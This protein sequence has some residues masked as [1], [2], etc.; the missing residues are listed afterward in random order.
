M[1]D[2]CLLVAP[3][4]QRYNPQTRRTEF[5]S[6]MQWAWVRPNAVVEQ[7]FSPEIAECQ[8]Y[9]S[10]KYPRWAADKHLAAEFQQCSSPKTVVHHLQASYKYPRWALKS[11]TCK[12][13]ARI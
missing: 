5:V 2:L 4:L 9:A 12:T 6:E 1:T 7:Y 11:P 13:A 3:V 8:I 10:Y